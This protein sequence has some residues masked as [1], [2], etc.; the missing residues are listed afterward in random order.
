MSHCTCS[1]LEDRILCQIV[2]LTPRILDEDSEVGGGWSEAAEAALQHCLLLPV[3]F[4]D[5]WLCFSLATECCLSSTV[6]QIEIGGKIWTRLT[7]K[8]HSGLTWLEQR[9]CSVKWHQRQ[10]R[11][12]MKRILMILSR[13]VCPFKE[14]CNEFWGDL[15]HALS[16]SSMTL[17]TLIH[18]LETMVKRHA[19]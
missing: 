15:Q 6:G 18:H 12:V 17:T 8:L 14:L 2:R 3:E 11:P 5:R 7:P 10:W 1:R 19:K 4:L 13:L 16:P 9:L